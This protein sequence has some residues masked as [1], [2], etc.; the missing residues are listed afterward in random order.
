MAELGLRQ[1]EKGRVQIRQ[2]FWTRELADPGFG[3]LPIED[4][5]PMLEQ[6][7][8]PVLVYAELL[9]IGDARTIETGRKLR[10]EW[11]DRPFQ[12]YRARAAV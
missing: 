5:P 6:T 2:M 9:A 11:I 10:E 3:D 7:A 4:P 12:R 8:P 1:D